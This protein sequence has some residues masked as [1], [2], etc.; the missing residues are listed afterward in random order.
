[1]L[2]RLGLH[3]R[4]FRGQQWLLLATVHADTAGRRFPG[5]ALFRD[6]SQAAHWVQSLPDLARDARA[7]PITRPSPPAA[8]KRWAAA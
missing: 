1:M 4:Q 8:P 7:Q 2:D 5:Q 3:S 6:E